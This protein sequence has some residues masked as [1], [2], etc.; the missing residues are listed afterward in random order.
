MRRR[1]HPVLSHWAIWSKR[2]HKSFDLIYVL[3]KHSSSSFEPLIVVASPSILSFLR[4][5]SEVDTYIIG[6]YTGISTRLIDPFD[7]C[8]SFDSFWTRDAAVA[9][10]GGGGGVVVV[11]FEGGG[12]VV[13]Y[14]CT[15]KQAFLY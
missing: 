11:L 9:L 8:C 1:Q 7:D 6:A 5:Y 4:D 10:G 15:S 14:F 3:V 12:V 2:Y 13:L